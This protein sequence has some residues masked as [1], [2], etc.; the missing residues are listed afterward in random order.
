MIDYATYISSV[1]WRL[2]A[3]D[4]KRRAGWVCM[5]CEATTALEVHHRTYARLGRELPTDLVVLCWRCHR[6]HHATLGAPR[7]AE[8][9]CEQLMLPFTAM[10]PH[11]FELN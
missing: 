2:K 10:V 7:A 5:L 1:E 4:A 3:H 9:C 6:R 8:T 11:G